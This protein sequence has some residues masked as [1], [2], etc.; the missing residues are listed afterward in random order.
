MAYRDELRS[1]FIREV[2]SLT[3]DDVEV[4]YNI[5]YVNKYR[6]AENWDHID[7]DRQR[8]IEEHILPLLPSNT[9]PARVKSFDS[10]VLAIEEE[11]RRRELEGKDPLKIRYG[12]ANAANELTRRMEALLKL[13]N[14]PEIVQN[15]Q[16]ITSMIRGDYLFDDF[17]LERAENVRKQLR[18]L[19][20]Y[21]PDD[22]RYYVVDYPDQLIEKGKSGLGREPSYQEK[23]N[24]YLQNSKDPAL[25][26][27]RNLEPLTDEERARLTEVFTT[28][29]GTKADYNAWSNGTAL[30]PFLRKRVGISNEALDLRFGS[31]LNSE[32]LNDQQLEYMRQVIAYARENGDVTSTDLLSESP[33]RDVNLSTFFG[34]D[35]MAYLK[36]LIN[37][38]HK[39]V[40]DKSASE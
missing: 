3:N 18:D 36:Q 7:D 31:F 26:K 33:F 15:E 28:K 27:L 14:I 9:A 32:T 6:I 2:R 19:M 10:L 23:A 4:E 37:G 20:V 12:F 25:A 17:S 29:L 35:K 40:F 21:L 13:R 38:L 34:Q 24:D 11:Y 8:E 22:K 5:S 1:S 39:P 16:L 30:L